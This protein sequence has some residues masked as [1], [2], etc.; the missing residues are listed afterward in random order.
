[1][2]TFVAALKVGP[3][4]RVVGVDMTD[5][6]LQKA[7]R[8]RQR[9][10]VAQIEY[11]K[12]YIEE[13]P[14]ADSAFDLVISNGVI[15]LA[16]DKSKVFQTIARVLKPGGRMAVADIVSDVAL[17]ETISTNTELW[18]SCIGGAMERRGYRQ[19]IEA[20]GLKIRQVRDNTNYRFISHNATAATKKFGVK[21][22]SILA[23]KP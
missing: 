6:Q 21:S 1:M 2:D 19:A 11:R 9:A 13:P 10:G 7:E 15:N 17:P 12:G 20:A 8:L 18:A 16:P 4:G 14:V 23:V 22:V 5:A 3:R